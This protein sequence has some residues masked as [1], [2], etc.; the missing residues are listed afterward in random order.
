MGVTKKYGDCYYYKIGEVINLFMF[1]FVELH[2]L[3]SVWYLSYVVFRILS[4]LCYLFYLYR[5]N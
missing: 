1:S 2:I 3:S 4:V 5:K